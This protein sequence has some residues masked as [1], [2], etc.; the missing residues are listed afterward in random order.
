M[1]LVCLGR[2]VCVATSSVV[3]TSEE[4]AKLFL[5]EG[6]AIGQMFRRMMRVPVFALT[7]VFAGTDEGGRR[8]LSR[9]YKL[10]TEGFECDIEEVFPDREMFVLGERWLQDAP[11][12]EDVPLAEPL[13]VDGIDG[14]N[15]A[16]GA[17]EKSPVLR[18]M[19]TGGALHTSPASFVAPVVVS[20]V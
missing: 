10:D 4:C 12:E 5:D 18:R 6:Y 2:T 15:G 1:R 3:L 17:R 11:E 8:V 14:V 13:Q 20:Q 19:E 7:D 9:R 16:N